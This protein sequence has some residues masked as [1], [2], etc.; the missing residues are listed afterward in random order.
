[1]FSGGGVGAQFDEMNAAYLGVFGENLPART[2][3][4]AGIARPGLLVEI[5]AIA[6]LASDSNGALR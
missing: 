1:M 6:M 3:V 5:D 2:T 4:E